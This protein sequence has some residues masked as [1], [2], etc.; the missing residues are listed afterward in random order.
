[1][2]ENKV[3]VFIGE[4]SNFPSAVFTT[5]KMAEEWI[6]R[7]S[8]SGMLSVYPLDISL[9]DWAIKEDFFKIKNDHEKA[10][11]FIQRFTSASTEHY[12]YEDGILE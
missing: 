7:Y 4:E 8:L 12:H 5:L 9:Y 10:P 11:K 2:K 6:E 3:Y 1:M